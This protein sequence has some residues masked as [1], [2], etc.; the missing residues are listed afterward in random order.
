M[1]N[2]L[3]E[4]DSLKLIT[5]MISTAK[6]NVTQGSFHMLLWGWVVITVSIS[7][8]LLETFQ[9]IKHPEI[10]W[11]AMIPTLVISLGVGFTRGRKNAV[12]THLDNIYMWIWLGLTIS[13]SLMIYYVNGKWDIISSMVLMMAGYATFLSGKLIKFKPMVYGGIAFWMWSLIA[14]FAGFYYGLLIIAA[15]I[16][17]GY[18]VPGLMLRKRQ[19]EL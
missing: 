1:E 5:K 17:T 8:F 10:V 18:V 6:G 9:V 11:L 2:K 14:Y 12:S 15:A 4:E 19:N 7:H 3:T 13:V 16:F